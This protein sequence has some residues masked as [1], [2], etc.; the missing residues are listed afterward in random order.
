MPLL[1]TCIG[2]YPKPGFVKLPDWF[3]V[4]AGPDTA[5]PTL[6]WAQ[7]MDAMGPDAAAIIDKGVA[8]AITDQVDAGIDIPTDGEII[9]ENYIHYHCRHLNGFDFEG[10]TNKAVRGGTYSA[11]LPTIRGTVSIDQP[12]LFKEWQAAQSHTNNPVKMTTKDY[13]FCR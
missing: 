1:T 4:D 7:A 2:A 12:F 6:L 9:R 10:L 5:N 13:K 8:Q 11:N 3:T